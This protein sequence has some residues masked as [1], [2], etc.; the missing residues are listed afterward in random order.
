MPRGFFE[1]IDYGWWIIVVAFYVCLVFSG[2]IFFAFSL[3]VKPLQAEFEWSRSSIMGAFTCLYLTLAITSPF[4]GKAVDRFGAK[5][6]MALGC[7][8]GNGICIA[9]CT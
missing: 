3:F 6:V 8:H 5:S 9:F 2:C 1:K 4:A 7:H